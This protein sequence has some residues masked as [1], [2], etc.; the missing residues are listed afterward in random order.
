MTPLL[1]LAVNVVMG[2]VSEDEVDGIVNEVMV[3]LVVSGTTVIIQVLPLGVY[4][5][6]HDTT[7][8]VP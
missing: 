7:V 1:S 4:P 6:L 5:L 8:H 3:G 2:T